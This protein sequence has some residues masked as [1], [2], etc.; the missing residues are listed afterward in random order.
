MRLSLIKTLFLTFFLV[1]SI[2]TY[3]STLAEDCNSSTAKSENNLKPICSNQEN[4]QLGLEVEQMFLAMLTKVDNVEF[5]KQVKITRSMFVASMYACN[6]N[7][8]QCAS[9]KLTDLKSKF[10]NL[11]TKFNFI[12]NANKSTQELVGS[13][14][15]AN[16]EFALNRLKDYDNC[17]RKNIN[18]L[19]DSVS[20]A[21]VIADAIY[22]VCA[23]K[24]VDAYYA[25]MDSRMNLEGSL[26]YG[27]DYVLSQGNFA[28]QMYGR[29][30]IMP[31]VL[32]NRN[33]KRNNSTNQKQEPKLKNSSM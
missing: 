24:A 31:L 33:L 18:I 19:D 30:Y 21:D 5:R 17:I 4:F 12:L 10:Q 15:K 8:H 25:V 13:V 32:A 29:K 2:N 6:F 26:F 23:S 7:G 22:G 1:G 3:A 28:E 20:S 9:D 11:A 16:A 14:T 27:S